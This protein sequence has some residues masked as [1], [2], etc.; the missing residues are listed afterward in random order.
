MANQQALSAKELELL[1]NRAA[2]GFAIAAAGF[3]AAEM[4]ARL[5]RTNDPA[6][7]LATGLLGQARLAQS[8]TA[9]A[10]LRALHQGAVEA[11]EYARKVGHS[12]K[13]GYVI[14][15]VSYAL[16]AVVRTIAGQD[17]AA[18]KA[19]YGAVSNAIRVLAEWQAGDRLRELREAYLKALQP[20]PDVA[21]NEGA[22]DSKLAFS[23]W[24]D[25]GDASLEEIGEVLAALNEIHFLAGGL[26]LEFVVDEDKVFA[27]SAV[28]A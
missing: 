3:A 5:G 10:D 7:A 14:A 8:D 9:R 23:L 1:E 2:A 21:R 16:L 17:Q 28:L 15:A 22:V 20:A 19:V 6:L 18:S 4:E 12:S 25:P 26:G 24:I 13:P 11:A 27:L